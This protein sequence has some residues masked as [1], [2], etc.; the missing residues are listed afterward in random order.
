MAHPTRHFP[1][2]CRLHPRPQVAQRQRG[3]VLL[4]TLIALMLVLLAASA[5]VRSVDTSSVLA[6]NLAFRRD[7]ANQAERGIVAARKLLLTGAL[8]SSGT[9]DANQL[10]YNYSAVKLANNASGVPTVLASDTA[11]TSAGMTGADLSGNSGTVRYVIDRQCTAAGEFGASNCQ[12]VEGTT[13]TA[14]SSWQRRPGAESRPIYR[15]SVRVTGPRNA[16]AFYQST[17]AL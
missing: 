9:R 3:V 11:F 14:G 4:F 12:V 1:S 8:M 16:Q 17:F 2:R 6:G 7:L 15:I 5:M 10:A 13:D